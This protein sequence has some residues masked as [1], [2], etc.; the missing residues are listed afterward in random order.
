MVTYIKPWFFLS[1][2][3]ISL[4][5]TTSKAQE[6]TLTLDRSELARGETLTLTIRVYDQRQG[7]QLDLTPLTE[8]FDVLGTRTSSQVRSI[9]GNTDIWTDYIITLF[10]LTE[11]S[12]SIPSLTIYGQQTD[13]LEVTVTNQGARSNQETDELFLEIEVNKD[14]LYVQEQLLFSIR[15]FYTINGIRNPVFTEIDIPDTV[16][17]LIGSPNQY[18]KIIDGQRYGVYEKRYVIFPQKSGSLDIPDIL[19]RG[20]VTDG[21]SSFVFRNLNTR[22]ITAFIEGRTIDVVERP[23]SAEMLPTWLPVTD[24]VME[25]SFSRPLSDLKVGDSLVRTIKMTANG[26]D[27]AVLPPFSP[28]NIQGFNTYPDP[29]K[30]ERRFV[31]G[32]IVGER[33][34]SNTLVV[35]EDGNLSIPAIKIDWWNVESDRLDSTIIQ[36]TMLRIIPLQGIAPSELAVPSTESIEDLLAAPPEISQEMVDEQATGQYLN[37]EEILVRYSIIIGFLLIFVT[38]LRNLIIKNRSHIFAGYAGLRKEFRLTQSPE[39]NERNAYR[40]LMRAF[41]HSDTQEIKATLIQWANHIVGT[42]EINTI[43]DL[44]RQKEY[45]EIYGPLQNF[46]SELF[47]EKPNSKNL[48]LSN[49]LAAVRKI[50]KVNKKNNATHERKKRYH[51]P[52]LYPI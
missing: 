34:E 39:R 52:P 13:E 16:T 26:V 17:Q 12:L 43:E 37:I 1:S 33:I 38:L 23:P 36:E 49:L 5:A 2:L 31:N 9:N 30:I 50:R 15:L 6:I 35:L 22:R 25:E 24:L 42:I 14:S 46:Q 41:R 47:S 18:E 44:Y 27:G 28:S 7:M 10:P 32:S 8:N 11:G 21:S 45:P 20:E 3:L 29:A 19:F 4:L 51:L 40:A 48:E